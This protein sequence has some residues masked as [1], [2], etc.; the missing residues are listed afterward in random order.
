MNQVKLKDFIK[1]KNII[2][3]RFLLKEYKNFNLELDEFVMLLFLLD[4]DGDVFNPNLLMSEMNLDLMQVMM[5]ISN[6]TD[7]GI[8]NL[9]TKKNESGLM[10]EIID[11][12]PIWSKITSNVISDLNKIE[13]NDINIHELI[14][15]EFNRKLS[16][17]EHEMIDDWE[18]NNYSNKLIKEA[19]REASL[20]GVTTLRY[21]DKILLDWDRKGIKCKEEIPK[22]KEK[23]ESPEIVSYDWLNE[24][25]DEI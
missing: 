1:A 7:K 20:N 15:N 22:T 16:P 10:E 11:L 9:S 12:E 8:I 19:V 13:N 3:P 25:D 4:K 14:E 17:L 23:V 18:N 6:L 5:L 24:D 2:V 21:I